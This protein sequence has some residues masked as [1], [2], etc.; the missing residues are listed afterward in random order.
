MATG[1]NDI[2][3]I[4]TP[5]P[6]Q[7]ATPPVE[8]APAVPTPAVP[9]PEVPA[10]PAASDAPSSDI[11]SPPP[12][13]PSYSAPAYAVPGA[14][15]PARPQGL[16]LASIVCG[17]A[18]VLLSFGGIGLLP[19]IAAVVTGHLARKRQPWARGLWLTGMITG[20]VGLGI[21][22]IAGILLIIVIAIGIAHSGNYGNNGNYGYNS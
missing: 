22:I 17:I 10:V 14:Y 21:S 19:S 13:P 2:T 9:T 18:G 20:Y 8:P 11:P 5:T 6:E 12:P 7:S 16:S 4:P 3:P 1:D 15:A